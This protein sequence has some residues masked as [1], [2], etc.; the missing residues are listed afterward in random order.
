MGRPRQWELRRILNAIFYLLRSG[1]AW[2]LLPRQY[3][4]WPTVHDYYR[5]WRKDGT[6]E[7]IHGQLRQQ[8][9]Q[10]MGRQ[11]TP[12]AAILDSQSVKTTEK[13]ALREPIVSAMTATRRS[14]GASAICWWIPRVWCLKSRPV[15]PLSGNAAGPKSC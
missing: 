12:S 4:P 6:W 15:A 13:G 2:R 11:A 3:P 5:R 7:R 1:C 8:L 14:R 10:Q 9:R